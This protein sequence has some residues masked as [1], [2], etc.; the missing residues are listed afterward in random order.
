MHAHA[1]TELGPRLTRRVLKRERALEGEASVTCLRLGR[2][3][4]REDRIAREAIEWLRSPVPY[5]HYSELA[6]A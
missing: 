2:V 6:F 3:P 5:Q 4:E 1:V